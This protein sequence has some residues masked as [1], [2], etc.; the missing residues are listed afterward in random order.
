M[1][2]RFLSVTTLISESGCTAG[3]SEYLKS[4]EATS[5]F[6]VTDAGID[7]LGLAEPAIASL[8]SAGLRVTVDTQ[9]TAD[10]A[11]EQILKI[12]EHAR[13]VDADLIIGFGGGSSMDAAKLVALLA[14]P[15]QTQTIEQMY[16]VDQVTGNR[17]PLIQIPTTAGTGSEVTPVAIVTRPDQ[18]KSGVVSAKLIAD[19]A[20]L[21]ADLTLGLPRHITAETG[22]DAMVHAI[23]AYTSKRLKNP[24]SDMHAIKALQLIHGALPKALNDGADQAARSD[25]LLGACLAGQAFANAPV[26]AVHALAYP[27]GARYHLAH[28]LTNALV[29]LK[30]LE[31][32]LSHAS[33]LYAEL[34][35]ALEPDQARG[36][37]VDKQAAMLIDL[38]HAHIS[39][40]RIKTRLR[41]HG[42]NQRDL[43]MLARDAM[44]QTRLLINNPREMNEADARRIY[45]EVW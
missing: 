44:Q 11:E 18:T 10:P 33:S 40:A 24:I 8:E 16:G 35:A 2:L 19:M 30:V 5:V 21:D 22:I 45:A 17:L 14:N 15:H 43:D 3:L 27:L 6:L 39:E 38:L 25:M 34:F 23:E 42:V 12:A 4:F 1:N 7:K 36:Q 31:F 9:V 26:A 28:G 29:L 37:S 32:N 13:Q 20:L 41:D